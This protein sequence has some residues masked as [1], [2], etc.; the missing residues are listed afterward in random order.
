MNEIDRRSAE[1]TQFMNE[2]Y[3]IADGADFQPIDTRK[4]AWKLGYDIS[5]RDQRTRVLTITRYLEGEGLIKLTG[6]AGTVVSLTHLGVVEV[7]EARS[8][9]D[10][11]TD[12]FVPINLVYAE[13]IIDS[14]IQQGSPG[15]TQSL[16]VLD[17]NGTQELEKFTRLLRQEIE[18]LDLS[19]SSRT[20]L[21]ADIQTLEAQ[22]T[23]PNPK[24]EIIKP[25]LQSIQRILEGTASGMVASGL[26]EAVQAL[27]NTL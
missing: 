20:E 12:H 8:R 25:G 1:R 10:Q 15:A 27:S 21:E 18:K 14:A 7:E 13:T 2:L 9:P 5:D 17:K 26:I 6:M 24:K 3:D 11:P 19:A 16:T 4:V 22:A 23:S